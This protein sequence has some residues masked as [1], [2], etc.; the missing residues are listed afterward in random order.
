ML[1]L[2]SQGYCKGV[3]PNTMSGVWRMSENCSCVWLFGSVLPTR[4]EN[5]D[6]EYLDSSSCVELLFP[7]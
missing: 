2:E 7:N 4:A 5:S 6:S 3:V 1:K